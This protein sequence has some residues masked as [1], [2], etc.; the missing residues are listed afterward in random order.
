MKLITEKVEDVQYLTELSEDGKKKLYIEGIFLQAECVNKNKR[1]YS[2]GIM[3]REVAR[4]G[5]E[6]IKENRALGELGH[7]DGPQVNLD[8]VSHRI[9]SLK[10]DG[11][12]YIGKALVLDTPMG[13]IVRNL[14]EG[15]TKLGVSSRGLGSLKPVNGINEVQ[16]DFFLATAADVVHDP[17]AQ[18]AF[19]D[20]IME[21]KEWICESG[22]F[23]P[24]LIE[25]T[26][27]EI[28]Q[29]TRSRE[30][31]GKK[32]VELFDRFL[33]RLVKS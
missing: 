27:K 33:N 2:K 10:E 5:K 13:T 32:I 25:D 22:I 4:Y 7:P 15:G 26:K 14:I 9:I 11:N 19:I 8:R 21:N 3:E 30:L 20:G 1:K 17:S 29:S 28:E 12:N 16:D 24:R 31:D 23:V 6:Y 18:S